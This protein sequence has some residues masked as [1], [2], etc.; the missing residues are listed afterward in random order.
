MADE[1]TIRTSNVAILVKLETTPGVDANPDPAVDA[2]PFEVDSLNRNSPFTT[3]AS[4]EATGSD[5]ASAPLVIGQP[6]TIGWRSR[7]KGAGAGAVYTSSVKPPLHAAFQ[8]SGWRGQFQAAIAAALATA[9]STTSATLPAGFPATARALIGMPLI[10]GAGVG[11]GSTP[12]IIEYSAAR[13]AT[14]A[15]IFG[16]ALDATTSLSMPANWT[17]AGTSPADAS[18]RITDQPTATIYEYRDG[19]LRKYFGCRGV[20]TLDGRTARPGFGAFSFSGIFGGKSD[21]SVPA[22]IAIAGHLAPTLVQGSS[23]S[24]A[25]NLNR[26][27]LSISTWSLDAGAQV[28]SSEDP[29]TPSGFG[30]GQIGGR[31]PQLKVDPLATLVA[32]RDTLA[33]ISSGALASAVFRHGSQTGNRWSLAL[34]TLQTI[35]EEDG[36][37][38]TN[39]SEQ[40][41]LQALS[42]GK[43]AYVRD[44]D[45]VLC[46]Y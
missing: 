6:A 4:N 11:A 37:R 35:T 31:A 1:Y 18:A 10:I 42:A 15:D 23:L 12:T 16:T 22:N 3:E 45:R 38:E 26:K 34:P 46:F 17:Y 36:V 29:N 43:D 27:P 14:L 7:I 39:M 30:K 21:A 32:N 33:S 13:L 2:I 5:V 8:A 19:I 20:L 40:I 9:G 28:T 25:V 24:N 44:L 41:T